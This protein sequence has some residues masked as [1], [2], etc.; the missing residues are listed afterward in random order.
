MLAALN[1]Q[2]VLTVAKNVD[3]ETLA[4]LVEFGELSGGLGG[5]P[6]GKL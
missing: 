1:V 6:D 5:A 2:E 4:A 3:K